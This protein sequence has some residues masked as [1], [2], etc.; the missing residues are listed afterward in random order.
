M[1]KLFLVA[2]AILMMLGAALWLLAPSSFNQ[3]VYAELKNNLST[4]TNSQVDIGHVDAKSF[5]G[6]VHGITARSENGTQLFRIDKIHYQVDKKSFKKPPVKIT[7]MIFTGVAV[8]QD[9]NLLAQLSTA[10]INYRKTIITNDMPTLI[11]ESIDVQYAD[12]KQSSNSK[13]PFNTEGA[14]DKVL[15]VDTLEY[16][17]LNSVGK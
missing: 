6:D 7:K 10:L 15:L 8:S 2:I 13:S 4:A 5:S 12:N 17:L 16:V 11:I 3:F 1:N 9:P 14:S